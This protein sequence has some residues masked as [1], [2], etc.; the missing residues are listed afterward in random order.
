VLVERRTARPLVPFSIFRNRSVTA[1]NLAVLLMGAAMTAL[2]FAFS[3]YSQAV[4]GYDALAAG[5]SQLPLAGALV[6]TAGLV[7]TVIG[8]VGL[9]PTLVGSLVVLTG[10]LLWLAAAPSDAGFA[11]QLLGPTLLIGVGLGGAFVSATQLAM[12]GVDDADAGLA[13]GLVNTGQ[14]VG[15]AIGLAVL[16]TLAA[17]VTAGSAERGASI[18]DALTAGFSAVFVGAA[19]AAALAA[20]VVV[21]VRPGSRGSN[22]PVD[23]AASAG[24]EAALA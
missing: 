20:L 5:L 15:S 4:L 13:G 21:L 16:S 22:V 7:P 24:A 14:Q 9:R 3:V 8:R 23:S 11:A 1:G 12:H 19:V 2:F 17:A 18:P 6:V 10:A